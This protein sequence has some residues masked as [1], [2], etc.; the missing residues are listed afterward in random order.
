MKYIVVVLTDKDA[1]DKECVT[2]RRREYILYEF[3]Q[4]DE[5]GLAFEDFELFKA[6]QQPKITDS[7]KS[8]K[9]S[10]E[11]IKLMKQLNTKKAYRMWGIG[12]TMRKSFNYLRDKRFFEKREALKANL[13]SLPQLTFNTFL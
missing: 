11:F 10:R 3:S 12:K 6:Q 2:F 7:K 1:E 8:R 9:D 5:H 4:G 13:R